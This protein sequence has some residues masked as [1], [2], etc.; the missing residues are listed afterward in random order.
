MCLGRS[1]FAWC[2]GIRPIHLEPCVR[3]L[4]ATRGGTEFSRFLP[5]VTNEGESQ[6]VG[7]PCVKRIGIGTIRWSRTAGEQETT[8]VFQISLRIRCQVELCRTRKTQSTRLYSSE[9]TGGVSSWETH[10]RI[11]SPQFG[12]NC[13]AR[14]RKGSLP[15]R[16][17]R[18]YRLPRLADPS[19]LSPLRHTNGGAE[20]A[21]VPWWVSQRTIRP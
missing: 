4:Y 19:R 11:Y 20:G 12:N 17:H 14:Y 7:G 5:L 18:I 15:V 2:S 21:G 3:C 9:Q 16:A 8:R 13:D 6:P 10:P 1:I